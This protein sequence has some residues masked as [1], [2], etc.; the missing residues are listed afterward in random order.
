M[1][2]VGLNAVVRAKVPAVKSKDPL[3]SI[4]DWHKTENYGMEYSIR[5]TGFIMKQIDELL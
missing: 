2:N 1:N 5:S 3:N 4:H